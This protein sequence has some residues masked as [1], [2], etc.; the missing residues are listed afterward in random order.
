MKHSKTLI[1]LLALA[2]FSCEHNDSTTP[3]HEVDYSLTDRSAT[4][5]RFNLDLID[6]G[7][8]S[9][10]VSS[11]VPNSSCCRGDFFTENN[12]VALANGENLLNST[13]SG[14][15]SFELE[16]KNFNDGMNYFTIEIDDSTNKNYFSFQFYF[17][18]ATNEVD[19][20]NVS[21]NGRNGFVTNYDDSIFK[22]DIYTNSSIKVLFE[23]ENGTAVLYD[24]VTNSTGQFSYITTGG[25]TT[26]L[27]TFREK[28]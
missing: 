2:F 18:P 16:L 24:T 28:L 20:L 19:Y 27:K 9:F 4:S 5:L 17:D 14:K 15:D 12:V 11:Y 13:V 8:D 10:T 26:I 3:K 7:S 22:Y 1:L 6:D 23:D 21:H 25:G